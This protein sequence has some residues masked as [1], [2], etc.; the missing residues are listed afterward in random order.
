MDREQDQNARVQVF[1]RIASVGR[2]AFQTLQV[3][4]ILQAQVGIRLHRVD[5]TVP[6]RSHIR[7]NTFLNVNVHVE[8]TVTDRPDR[9]RHVATQEVT[10]RHGAVL[11]T[12]RTFNVLI[13]RARHDLTVLRLHKRQHGVT[14]AVL[15]HDRR[16]PLLNGARRVVQMVNRVLL[17]RY[18]A[19]RGRGR[20]P[21]AFQRYTLKRVIG[22]EHRRPRQRVGATIVDRLANRMYGLLS[23]RKVS[24]VVLVRIKGRLTTFQGLVDIQRRL[25]LLTTSRSKRTISTATTPPSVQCQLPQSPWPSQSFQRSQPRRHRRLRYFIRC[26]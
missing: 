2:R 21:V 24:R 20:Q 5:E 25:D 1:G 3:A 19:T 8:H 14:I 7:F 22:T 15:R 11:I 26:R 18:Q 12:V 23:V 17:I 16:V 13:R 4:I 6:V 10:P 9:R